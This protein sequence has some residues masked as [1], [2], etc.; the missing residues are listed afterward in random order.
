MLQYPDIS[1]V[2]LSLGK[3]QIHWYGIMYVV[4]FAVAWWLAR[5][6]AAR[7]GSTWKADDVDD[8]IFWCM[9][10]VIVGGRVGYVLIYVLGFQPELLR[11]DWLYPIKLWKGGMSFHGGLAGVAI[12][13]ALF[14]RTRGRR[15]LDV[16]D[17]AAPLPG[18]GICAVRIGNFINGE[19]WGAPTDWKYGFLVPDAATGQLIGRHATQLYE[20]FL[21]GLVMFALL[22]WFSRKPRPRGMLAGLFLSWYALVRIGVEFVRVPDSQIGYLM[23]DWLTMGQVLSWPMLVAGLWLLLQGRLQGQP[24]GN[25]AARA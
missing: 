21:E 13:T 25:Y 11:E 24:S 4:A 20:A 2:A 23:Q 15:V 18:I 1:P 10:G 8:F 14:A 9:V 7:P 5:R 6:Q 17:F 3:L 22:W 12:A 19:L 16:F